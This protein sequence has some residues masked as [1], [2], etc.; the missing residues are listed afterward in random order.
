M[1]WMILGLILWVGAHFYKRLAPAGRAAMQER[2][3]EASKGIFAGVILLSV[4]LM[5][6]GYRSSD[7]VLWYDLGGWTRHVNNLLMVIAVILFG[8]GS[9][10]SRARKMMR[11][12]MLT[13]MAVWAFAHLLVN[14]DRDS[15]ILFGVLGLWSLVQMALINNAEPGYRAYEGGSVKGDIRLLIISAVVFCVIAAIH[16]WLGK[17]PFTG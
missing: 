6:I 3:G 16:I 1:I 13:G 11:H 17:N 4:V 15:V 14:G 8:L 12:P 5:V 10:K 2:F 7:F 9:S